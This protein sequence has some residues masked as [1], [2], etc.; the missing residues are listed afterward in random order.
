MHGQKLLNCKVKYNIRLNT[1]LGH[2][3]ESC[4]S[5]ALSRPDET[6]KMLVRCLAAAWWRH[7]SLDSLQVHG[8]AVWIAHP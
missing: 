7:L 1:V 6:E 2:K 4:Y 5:L 3:T 8:P